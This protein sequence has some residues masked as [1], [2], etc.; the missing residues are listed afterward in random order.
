MG[1]SNKKTNIQVA[2][3][4]SAVSGQS[5]TKGKRDAGKVLD[6]VVAKKQKTETEMV[7]QK[8]DIK[9]LKKAQQEVPSKRKPEAS[10]SDYEISSN[11]EEEVKVPPKKQS[12]SA[13][14]STKES[15]SSE[16]S[17]SDDELAKTASTPI[18]NSAA[19]SRNGSVGAV[20]KQGEESSSSESDSDED[21]ASNTNKMV[22]KRAN[23]KDPEILK[24]FLDACIEESTSGNRSGSSF[25]KRSWDLIG[26]L[27]KEKK[28]LDLTQKQLKNQL[29]YLKRKY[30]IWERIVNKTGNG[31]DPI[32]NTVSWTS[33]EW[34]DYT[35][36]Y[37][38]AKQFRYAGLQF[39]DEMKSLFDGITA[40][41]KDAWG[42]QISHDTRHKRLR[43][44]F[45]EDASGGVK[46]QTADTKLEKEDESSPSESDTDEGD[47]STGS[48][49]SE[50]SSEKSSD[51]ESEDEKPLKISKKDKDVMVKGATVDSAQKQ[52]TK[53]SEKTVPKTPSIQ[54]QTSGSRTL[55]VGNLSY[56]VG[57]EDL[58]EFFNAAGEVVAV[59]LAT[60]LDGS[61]KGFCHIDFATEEAVKK[62][63]ELNGQEFFG[64]ALRLEVAQERD[65]HTPLSGNG[66]DSKGQNY[67]IFVKGFDKSV[68]QDQIRNSLQEHFGSCGG[69]TR[70]SLP[71]DYESGALKGIAYMDFKDQDAYNKAFELNGT[72]LGEYTLT[73]DEAK[74]KGDN[75]NRGWNS[76]RDGGGRSGGKFGRSGGR[77]GRGD[78]GRG[79]GFSGRGRGRSSGGK[80]TTFG[81]D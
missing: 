79:R 49:S 33:E 68:G 23:W 24:T 39:A 77:R 76:G 7:V 4:V 37:P 80:K 25:K 65:S 67:T 8:E 66:K 70:I 73:V 75:S 81:D 64:R 26:N 12:K 13:K 14:A 43:E 63:V 46:K 27:M 15:S 42:N 31:Y 56:D 34:D 54:N 28:G 19:A 2:P 71:K 57:R 47:A 16:D 11:S 53:K 52:T 10:N 38:D 51:V 32:S 9:K 20:S 72:E 48:S 36:I 1:K 22:D 50:E 60:R 40:T 18:K 74:P 35:K 61:S 58:S 41:G 6:S 69:I 62:A 21:K 30:N 17:S 55:F 5:G 44:V 45:K 29:D 59:R 3:A 78:R